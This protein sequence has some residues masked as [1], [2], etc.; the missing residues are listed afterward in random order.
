MRTTH[1]RFGCTAPTGNKVM[2]LCYFQIY[3]VDRYTF[4]P[5]VY[6]GNGFSDCI[7]TCRRFRGGYSF[8]V[9]CPSFLFLSVRP[10]MDYEKLTKGAL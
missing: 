3:L 9:V 4:R 6:L 8:G 5:Y 2:A 10:A 1:T 7:I